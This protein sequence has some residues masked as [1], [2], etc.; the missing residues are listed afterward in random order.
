[1]WVGDRF[2]YNPFLLLVDHPDHKEYHPHDVGGD[3]FIPHF[4]VYVGQVVARDSAAFQVD[5]YQSYHWEGLHHVVW[6]K[7][8]GF[9][10]II[11]CRWKLWGMYNLL[12]SLLHCL[13]VSMGVGGQVELKMQ[14]GRW[15]FCWNGEEGE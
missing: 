1:M 13:Y 10:T 7:W 5:T 3:W 4:R 14:W 8:A 12:K 2:E 11:M 15:W 9:R 6:A